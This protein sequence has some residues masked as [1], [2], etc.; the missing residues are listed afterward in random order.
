ML[1]ERLKLCQPSP[2]LP[3]W[4]ECGRHDRDLLIGASKH[5]VSRTDYHI[6]NDSTLAFLE[7]HQRFTNQRGS[8]I[9]TG[10]QGEFTKAGVGAAESAP[11]ALFT[12][13]ELESV[14]AAAKI[15]VDA[16]KEVKTGEGKMDTE[17]K[18]ET[19]E[20]NNLDIQCTKTENSEDQKKNEGQVG[21][22]MD[23]TATGSPR[24]EVKEEENICP[25]VE[26]EE[27]KEKMDQ[28]EQIKEENPSEENKATTEEEKKS[29]SE[30]YSQRDQEEMIIDLSDHLDTSP[31]A[32]PGHK[33]VGEDE[34]EREN[35]ESPKS[36]KSTDPEKSPEGEEEDRMDDDDKSEKSS[37]AEG[38]MW[39]FFFFCSS[40][41]V[42]VSW[43]PPVSSHSCC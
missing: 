35:P 11:A 42:I 20:E 41:S 29:L 25:K 40:S 24:K 7:A 28:K 19:A 43:M 4:W 16:A 21:Q 26:K 23:E 2:D 34:G 14:A 9:S 15:A 17:V 38:R 32:Q 8:G 37:Q 22:E 13:A 27:T 31:K 12:P 18:K 3:E 10:V 36:L 6:L 30:D 33:T 1:S 39:L 5:G